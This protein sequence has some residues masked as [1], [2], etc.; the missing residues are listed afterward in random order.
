MY[1]Y[2]KYLFYRDTEYFKTSCILYENNTVIGHCIVKIMTTYS[3]PA[4]K[5]LFNLGNDQLHYLLDDNTKFSTFFSTEEECLMC[6]MFDRYLLK[7]YSHNDYEIFKKTI[8]TCL[9]NTD[10]CDFYRQK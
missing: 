9:Y 6:R 4:K 10:Y 7:F 2:I 3:T 1:S 8:N 5:I